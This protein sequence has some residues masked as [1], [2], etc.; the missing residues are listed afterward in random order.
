MNHQTGHADGIPLLLFS[1]VYRRRLASGR[2]IVMPPLPAAVLGYV[3]HGRVTVRFGGAALDIGSG[4]CLFLTPHTAADMEAQAG[5]L[6]VYILFVRVVHIPGRRRS[7]ADPNVC[8]PVLPVKAELAHPWKALERIE[9]LLEKFREAKADRFHMNLQFQE[10]LHAIVNDLARPDDEP[11]QTDGIERSIAY[12]HRHY[13][14]KIK[15]DTLSDIAGFTR[16]SYSR[17]FKKSMGVPP[18][19]YL[20]AYRIEQAKQMLLE[21]GRTVKEVSSAIGFGSEFYFSRMFKRQVGLSPTLYMRRKDRRVAAVSCIRL[22]DSLRSLGIEPVCA[23]N[24]R[25]TKTMSMEEHARTLAERLDAVRRSEPELII[26]DHYHL[27][28]L[29]QLRS[30]AP[31]V[32][33]DPSMDWQAVYRQTAEIAGRGKEAEET[34]RAHS[35]EL[36]AA[37]RELR[38]RFGDETVA[39]VRFIHKLIRLQ[40]KSGHPLN[41]LIYAELGLKPGYCVSTHSMTMEYSPAKPPPFDADHLFVQSEFF[42]PEDEELFRSVQLTPAWQT[43]KASI[44]GHVRYTA[45]W[46]AMSWTPAGRK[47]IVEQLLD[48]ARGGFASGS[49]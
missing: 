32:A 35:R 12:I 23:V 9:R 42:F 10:L 6:D 30:I 24:C 16:T 11:K 25:K 3:A 40:G 33:L 41:D 14:E 39:L 31:A 5:G 2:T 1:S 4:Q 17:T 36:E 8:R 46:A 19:D 38:R 48:Y 15:L 26:C 22:D 43:M 29:E 34:I 47:Q 13:P 21:T 18:I 45:N 49:S 44:G 20:N 37:G 27:P 7:G 28:Y